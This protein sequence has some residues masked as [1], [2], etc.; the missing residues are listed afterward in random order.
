MPIKGA[1]VR[2]L[3]ESFLSGSSTDTGDIRGMTGHRGWVR[4]IRRM[5]GITEDERGCKVIRNQQLRPE[6]LDPKELA[7]SMIGQDC[8]EMIDRQMS[9]PSD[10]VLLYE[11]ASIV[12][13]MFNNISAWNSTVTGLL[14]AKVLESY[15]KPEFIGD[16]LVTVMPTKLRV[17]KLIGYSDLLDDSGNDVEGILPGQPHPT[18]TATERYVETPETKLR[19]RAIRVTREAVFFDETR[20]QLLQVAAQV[21]E[22]LGLRRELRILDMVVNSTNT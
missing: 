1:T 7:Y 21:G 12:P 22:K 6:D 9:R 18:V 4:K 5:L 17:T 10:D 2:N 3:Y 16:M 14:E 8:V 20:G 19:G 13:A 11:D 15:R